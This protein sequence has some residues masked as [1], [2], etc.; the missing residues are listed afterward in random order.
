MY[1]DR[2]RH[3]RKILYEQNIRRIYANMV[4]QR[5][6]AENHAPGIGSLL[7]AGFRE[8]LEGRVLRVDLGRRFPGHCQET[9]R[10]VI[11][12]L[13]SAGAGM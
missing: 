13:T 10:P 2:A 1:G 4:R 8:E 5:Q 9:T 6:V 11:D 12:R 3:E 7:T